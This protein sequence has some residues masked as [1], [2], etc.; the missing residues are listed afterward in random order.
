[1]AI[2]QKHAF[3]IIIKLLENRSLIAMLKI[4][5]RFEMM[6]LGNDFFRVAFQNKGGSR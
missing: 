2:R 4:S 6:D 1:M 5:E 3:D